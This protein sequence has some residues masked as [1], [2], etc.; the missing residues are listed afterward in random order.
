MLGWINHYK[1]FSL[2]NV[3]VQFS[4]VNKTKSYILKNFV[5]L[6]S[7]ENI[8]HAFL[9]VGSYIMV[10]HLYHV[11]FFGTIMYGFFYAASLSMAIVL[12]LLSDASHCH[13]MPD[14]MLLL[15]RCSH[16][17]AQRQGIEGQ[18]RVNSDLY[19]CRYQVFHVRR[20]AAQEQWWY[21]HNRQDSHMVG[22]KGLRFLN[23]GISNSVFIKTHLK[24][25]C[26]WCM[27]K[28]DDFYLFA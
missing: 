15:S 21:H 9:W 22:M 11:S 2:I 7:V 28:L 26:I 4:Q 6:A 5:L 23:C 13:S 25:R 24:V 19:L 1:T 12:S 3:K 16:A 20:R 27:H 14:P 18:H 8:E 10:L 17:I